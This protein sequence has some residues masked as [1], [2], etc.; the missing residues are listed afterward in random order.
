MKRLLSLYVLLLLGI[1]GA[2]CGGGGGG[3][4]QP[5]ITPTGPGASSG[6]PSAKAS[7]T[8]P[9]TSGSAGATASAS[10]GATPATT[11]IPTLMPI[12]PSTMLAD[13]T[14]LGLAPKNLG[15]IEKLEPKKLR[16]VM[17]LLAKATGGKCADCHTEGDF[18]APTRR[19]KIAAKMWDEFVVKLTMSD[20]SPVFCDSCHQ[21]RFIQLD[22]RDKKGAL[23]DFMQT[24]FVDKMKRKD[25]KDHGCETCH[26]DDWNMTFLKQWGG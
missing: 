2:A 20:G 16:E 6:A 10:T 19:K 17:K 21:G 25:N 24:N 1:V 22:R 8:V 5:P 13:L 12:K 9:A 11:E 26:G 23:K 7:S 14:A 4:T 18:A 3:E 15:P